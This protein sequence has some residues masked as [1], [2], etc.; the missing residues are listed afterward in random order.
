MSLR[1]RWKRIILLTTAFLSFV[2]ISAAAEIMSVEG[3][4]YPAWLERGDDR[5]ALK[6]GQEVAA[7]DRVRTGPGGKVW[8][9]MVDEARVKLGESALLQLDS[10]AVKSAASSQSA[11]SPA[12]QQPRVVES[13]F[14]IIE[15][16]FR[17]TSAKIESLWERDLSVGLGSVATI[18]IR[19]TDLWGKV[20]GEAPFVVLIEGDIDITPADGSSAINLNQALNI[21]KA[22]SGQPGDVSTVDMAA[23]QALAPETEL[24]FGSGVM[25]VE[26]RSQL[27]LASFRSRASAQA[28]VDRLDRAGLPASVEAADVGGQ[29]WQRVVVE[30][31]ASKQDASQL[32]GTL[33]DDG[34]IAEPW[35][36]R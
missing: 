2:S 12:S 29:R 14:N 24:D 4:Q 18:G 26:G 6:P 20:D 7:G 17:Y 1:T 10:G 35:V 22:N 33:P 5:S 23:V 30:Q 21:Y 19:G 27:Q 9:T 31:L 25:S 28:L 13:S 32:A 3:L 16:A 34:D 11:S 15:G 8:L 36:R